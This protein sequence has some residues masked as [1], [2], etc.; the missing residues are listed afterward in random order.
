MNR[1]I[2]IIGFAS[3]SLFAAAQSQS[4]DSKG[5][6]SKPAEVKRP[7]DVATGQASG[8]RV[9]KAADHGI[10]H[11]DLATRESP[12]RQSTGTTAQDNSQQTK[13]VSSGNPANVKNVSA[14][15]LNRDGKADRGATGDVNGDGVPDAAAAKNSGHA[16]EHQAV[17]TPRDAASG[18]ATGKRQHEPVRIVKESDK[19]P[20]DTATGQ[21]SGKRQHKPITV[22]KQ[23]D[24]ASQN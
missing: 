20:R 6:S 3:L 1:K 22:T 2:L 19:S 13:A 12:T 23:A 16:T 5:Q 4:N 24:K 15:D 21:A 17:A 14:A 7:R 9:E 8:R 18:M 11:R 10:V